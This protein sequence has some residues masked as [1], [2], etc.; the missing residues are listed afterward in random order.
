MGR[1]NQFQNRRINDS[2]KVVAD[3]ITATGD[4]LT[5]QKL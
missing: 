3:S 5:T 2:K 4:R 1:L